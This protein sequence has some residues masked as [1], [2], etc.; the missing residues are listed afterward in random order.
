MS[1]RNTVKITCPKCKKECDY[2]IWESINIQLDPEMKERI[3]NGE[4]FL[5]KCP[6]CGNEVYV[7]YPVLYHDMEKKMMI[8]LLPDDEKEI[9]SAAK[10]MSGMDERSAGLDLSVIAEGY[11]NRI[12][13]SLRELQE[14]IY[15][16]DAGY[17]DRIIEIIKMLYLGMMAEKTPDKKVD[18]ILFDFGNDGEHKIIFVEGENVFASVPVNEE[19]YNDVQDAF[20]ERIEN[21][22]SKYFIYDFAWARS[23]LK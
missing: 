9:K 5:F 1:K 20:K 16:S 19:V 21:N 4:A 12:V 22:P 13:T 6:D 14:K 17:D 11:S 8:Y 3:L 23:L 18:E 10:F 15:I 7:N 2:L